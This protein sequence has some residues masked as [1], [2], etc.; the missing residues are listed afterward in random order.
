M[1]T[2]KL[3]E[4]V[5]P[6][7]VKIIIVLVI[8]YSIVPY[9]YAAR[10]VVP[11]ADDFVRGPEAGES[12]FSYAFS[13]MMSVY[14]SWQGTYFSDYLF[15]FFN[16]LARMGLT[17]VRVYCF[18][19]IVFFYFSLWVCIYNI[20][21][22]IFKISGEGRWKI[23]TVYAVISVL[24]SNAISPAEVFFWYCGICVY[25]IPFGLSLIGIG[26]L[27]HYVFEPKK[28]YLIGAMI[29]AFIAD[30]GVLQCGAVI[31]YFYLAITVWAI[32]K[33]NPQRLKVLAAFMVG[34]ISTLIN[35]C[36]PGN[37]VRH[38]VIDDSSL[39]FFRT[40]RF[41]FSVAGWEM[42]RLLR[43]TDFLFF[44]LFFIIIGVIIY[45]DNQ[46]IRIKFRHL[47]IAFVGLFGAVCLSSYPVILGYSK[48]YMPDRAYFILDAL[49]VIS[50]AFASILFGVFLVCYLIKIPKKYLYL[51][52]GIA[53]GAFIGMYGL[54]DKEIYRPVTQ[55]IIDTVTGVNEDFYNVWS[56]FYQWI[57]ES[58]KADV[59][60]AMP[61]HPRS[62]YILK[63]PQVSSDPSY[64]VNTMIAGYYNKD[65]VSIIWL[66]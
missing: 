48:A 58:E 33:K 62:T 7:V 64:W 50:A 45:R 38:D 19:S 51:A 25:T 23:V 63:Y 3:R 12:Y 1:T 31:C 35:V 59:V 11:V 61:G 18:I 37:Y 20:S 34:L 9:L 14:L 32:V 15:A 57:P 17:G 29:C 46:E 2:S 36:A 42:I 13:K 49:A 47:C 40:I 54:G 27:T 4:N 44:I 43:E 6:N 8:I 53:I 16:P 22:N 55:C 28:R 30:G 52:A 24:I 39:H 41:S 21:E 26:L 56:N 65:S 66:D 60:I 5:I 10:F